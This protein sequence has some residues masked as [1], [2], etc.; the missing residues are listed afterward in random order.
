MGLGVGVTTETNREVV[1]FRFRVELFVPD[2]ERPSFLG[3]GGGSVDVYE[4]GGGGRGGV[5]SSP[6][7]R[8]FDGDLGGEG[9]GGVLLCLK[10]DSRVRIGFR[11][12][13]SL[14]LR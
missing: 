3:T 6:P 4:R 10:L 5:S 13:V 2:V 12:G 9:R 1:S 7:S 8:Y 11:G 14:R